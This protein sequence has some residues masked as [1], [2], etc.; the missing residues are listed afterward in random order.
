TMGAAV[1]GQGFKFDN[2]VSKVEGSVSSFT[3]NNYTYKNITVN[4]EISKKLFMG[5]LAIN[6]NNIKLN[7]D[8]SVDL[9]KSEPEFNCIAL[10][11]DLHL[12]NLNLSKR[13]SSSNLSGLVRM[14]LSGNDIDNLN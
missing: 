14:N 8:G 3:V 11:D 4:G 9:R 2:L 13:D 6:E 1:K 5:S 10:I 7:F 12:A